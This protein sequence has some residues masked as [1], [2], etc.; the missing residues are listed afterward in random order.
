MFDKLLGFSDVDVIDDQQDTIK[1]LGSKINEKLLKGGSYV[2]LPPGLGIETDD[3]E[4][5]IIRP[6]N[7]QQKALIDVIT[8]QADVSQDRVMLETNY[9]WA[10][11]SLGITD[12]F[13]GKYDSSATSGTAKQY[14]INQ[15]AG[16]LESKRIM[17]NQAYAQLYELMFKFALA[18]ADQ[19]IPISSQG[20]D[21]QQ[22]FSHFNRMNFLKVDAAGEYYW[23]DEFIFD[24]DPTSTLLTNREAMWNQADLKLQS[25][26]FGP[27]SELETNYL[28]WLEQ[29]RN[30]YPNA[31]EIK[32]EIERRMEDRKQQQEMM[33]MGG[34]NVEMP[35]M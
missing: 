16:R 24:T 8:V 12:S 25:G 34:M 21:G 31:S 17:K 2:T 26:A 5:K 20:K 10:K 7:P 29:E 18:Y 14:S 27:L 9:T 32:K 13:Q 19:P 15:A 22:E 1:K 6:D 35:N 3:E 4:L 23:N 33:Q 30:G 28:Y 11:S